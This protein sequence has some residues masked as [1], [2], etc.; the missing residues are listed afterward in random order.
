MSDGLYRRRALSPG[1]DLLPG[2][3]HGVG[4]GREVNR[5]EGLHPQS[6]DNLNRLHRRTK[7]YSKSIDMLRD[8]IAPVC[9]SLKLI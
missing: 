8:S 5:N 6:M 7:G 9:L 3:R 2:N 4:K 1:A